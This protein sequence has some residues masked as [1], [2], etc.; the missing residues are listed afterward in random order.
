MAHG[1]PAVV[2]QLPGVNDLFIRHGE[3]GFFFNTAQEYATGIRRL[4]ED[5][6]LRREMGAAARNLIAKDF[7]D[8]K[9][10]KRIMALYGFTAELPQGAEV[11][12]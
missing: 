9:N 6:A 5:P 1:L 8:L 12:A 7:D 10:A 4:A 2:R 11:H 3:T